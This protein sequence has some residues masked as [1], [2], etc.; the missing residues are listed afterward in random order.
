MKTE[1]TQV[2][3]ASLFG[4]SALSERLFDC[5]AAGEKSMAFVFP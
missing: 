4:R 2:R 1:M 5:E 3:F